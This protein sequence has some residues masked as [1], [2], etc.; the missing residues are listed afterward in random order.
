MATTPVAVK[1]ARSVGATAG[2]VLVLALLLAS[3]VA[4]TLLVA[5]SAVLALRWLARRVDADW[6][7]QQ[8]HVTWRPDRAAFADAH[9]RVTHATAATAAAA[10]GAPRL[11]EAR[12]RGGSGAWREVSSTCPETAGAA[13]A[14]VECIV[15]DFI[16]DLWYKNLTP[17]TQF[18]GEVQTVVLAL[19]AALA[20]RLQRLNLGALLVRDTC[21]VLAEQLELYRRAVDRCAQTSREWVSESPDS[22]LCV[23]VCVCHSVGADV[24]ASLPSDARDR[25]FASELACEGD[26]LYA[27][28]SADAEQSALR[29]I[30]DAMCGLLM[31]HPERECG[32]LR[33]LTRELVAGCVLRPVVGFAAPFWINKLLLAAVRSRKHVHKGDVRGEPGGQLRNSHSEEMLLRLT[34]DAHGLWNSGLSPDELTAPAGRPQSALPPPPQQQRRLAPLLDDDAEEEDADEVA[35]GGGDGV[36]AGTQHQQQHASAVHRRG[37]VGSLLA[38]APPPP[39]LAPGGSRPLRAAGGLTARV[40]GSCVVHSSGD[41]AWSGAGSSHVSYDIHVTS[42]GGGPT[43]ASWLIHRRFSQF[44]RLHKRVKALRARGRYKLPPKRLL[45]HGTE[46]GF[47]DARRQL[48]DQYLVDMLADPRLA[49]SPEVADFLAQHSRGYADGRG[50]AATQ[51]ASSA[52]APGAGWHDDGDARSDEGSRASV[53]EAAASGDVYG[54]GGHAVDD[55]CSSTVSEPA[56][57][58]QHARHARHVAHDA[59]REELAAGVAAGGAGADPGGLSLPILDLVDCIFRLRAR[60]LVRRRMLSFTRGLVDLLV[61][62]AVD[63]ALAQQLDGL[64]T[65]ATVASLVQLITDSLW[66]TGVWHRTKTA[67]DAAAAGR[68][69]PAVG[70]PGFG[71]VPLGREAEAAA[72]LAAVRALLLGASG[73]GGHLGLGGT[74][75][76]AEKLIGGDAYGRGCSEVFGMLQSPLFVRQIG[77][78]LLEA[79]LAA[80]LPEMHA[81][82]WEVRTTGAGHSREGHGRHGLS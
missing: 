33:A 50:K 29:R 56:A 21:D 81:V 14:L 7:G 73:Q 75:A 74:A 53:S 54:G 45:F 51:A 13:E 76:A 6:R 4:Y 37:S 24:L 25:A 58:V 3:P 22:R 12:A 30:A 46:G 31:P 17:D 68:S 66:P 70:P 23:C 64:R 63:E 32:V 41:G 26:L 9:S 82:L 5:S 47:M 43:P 18:P 59:S 19:L 11:W 35:L 79:V 69:P 80:A 60:G 49:A 28:S 38:A 44:E 2:A 16:T 65:D 34:N 36:M 78:S 77:H 48:L 67:A 52:A 1:A 8:L 61:G 71:G 10:P 72:D 42:S 40:T 15:R 62:S 20:P 55:D 27:A 39:L 57:A